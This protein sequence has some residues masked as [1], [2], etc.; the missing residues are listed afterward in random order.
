MPPIHLA[1]ETKIQRHPVVSLAP[2]YAASADLA[3]L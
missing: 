2:R 3:D 1:E